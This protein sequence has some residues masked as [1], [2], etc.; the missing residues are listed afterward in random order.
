[1]YFKLSLDIVFIKTRETHDK[2]TGSDD[3]IAVKMDKN[4]DSQLNQIQDILAKTERKLW[5]H[6][7]VVYIRNS[8]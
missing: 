1:M 6:C 8:Q 4:T 7:N 3:E 5:R 2:Y